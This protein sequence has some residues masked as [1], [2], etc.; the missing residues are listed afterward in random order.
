MGSTFIYYHVNTIGRECNW[1]RKD[2]P[3]MRIVDHI[4]VNVF[5]EIL[6]SWYELWYPESR[7][8]GTLSSFRSRHELMWVR[9]R[10]CQTLIYRRRWR[11]ERMPK[12]CKKQTKKCRYSQT[13]PL[14]AESDTGA[15]QTM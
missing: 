3:Q 15:Q 13:I 6:Y 5:L 10:M 8:W 7:D 11:E 9:M 4:V 1:T 2:C 12:F 14:F